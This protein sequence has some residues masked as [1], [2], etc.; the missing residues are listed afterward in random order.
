[1]KPDFARLI[2]DFVC[3]RW[4]G[5]RFFSLVKVLLTWM[6]SWTSEC[7]AALIPPKG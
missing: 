5:R 1:M 3:F 4:V 6:V 2:D 7:S